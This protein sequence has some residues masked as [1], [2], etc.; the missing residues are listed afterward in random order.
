VK[1][2]V[3]ENP[4]LGVR[5]WLDLKNA[6]LT[7]RSP[8]LIPSTALAFG[9]WRLEDRKFKAITWLQREFESSLGYMRPCLRNK[10]EP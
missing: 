4:N 8:G 1:G 9:S 10:T 7:K 3:I 2:K 5:M 6:Y